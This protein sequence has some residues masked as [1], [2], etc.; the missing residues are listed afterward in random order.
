ME[1]STV[2]FTLTAAQIMSAKV[3]QT[4][5]T[6]VTYLGPDDHIRPVFRIDTWSEY[7]GEWVKGGKVTCPDHYT[8]FD[9]E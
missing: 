3:V 6:R 1:T 7:F 8:P 5:S 4:A 2:V 9:F